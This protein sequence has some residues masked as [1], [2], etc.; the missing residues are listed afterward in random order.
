MSPQKGGGFG[1]SG[2]KTKSK[3]RLGNSPSRGP[4]Q[5]F[6]DADNNSTSKF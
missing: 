1:A 4:V 5:K 2:K 3:S 6:P